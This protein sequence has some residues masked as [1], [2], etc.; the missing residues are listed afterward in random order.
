MRR[1]KILELEAKCRR[2]EHEIDFLLKQ[3]LKHEIVNTGLV[4][5]NGVEIKTSDIVTDGILNYVIAFGRVGYNCG[6]GL[7]GFV[8]VTLDEFNNI[9]DENFETDFETGEKFFICDRRVDISKIE[10]IGNIYKN[11]YEF[12]GKLD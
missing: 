7:T 5:K 6:I 4:D 9:K 8:M 12:C 10:V 11:K 2:L 1:N 3:H